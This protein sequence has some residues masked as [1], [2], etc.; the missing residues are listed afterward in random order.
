MPLMD[1]ADIAVALLAASLGLTLVG[2]PGHP[3]VRA[4]LAVVYSGAALLVLG[5]PISWRLLIIVLATGFGAVAVSR[6]ALGEIVSARPA[7]YSVSNLRSHI[8]RL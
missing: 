4:G 1:L 5:Q 8:P 2:A 6:A 3:R 7:A